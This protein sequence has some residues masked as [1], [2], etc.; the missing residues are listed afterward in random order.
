MIGLKSLLIMH[1]PQASTALTLKQLL[2]T[3]YYINESIHWQL[4]LFL[5]N[6]KVFSHPSIYTVLSDIMQAIPAYPQRTPIEPACP[7]LR[8][9][10][11]R[12]ELYS[13][14]NL[15]E[16]KVTERRWRMR[17]HLSRDEKIKL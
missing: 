1:P 4:N 15:V 6:I 7:S 16:M 5:K 13:S 14:S 3:C 17:R 10:V 12:Q 11:I 8:S 2:T 9:P